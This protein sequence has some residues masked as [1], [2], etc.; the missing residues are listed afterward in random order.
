MANGLGIVYMVDRAFTTMD[1]IQAAL[2]RHPVKETPWGPI[3]PP[4][5]RPPVEAV[6]SQTVVVDLVAEFFPNAKKE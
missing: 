2:S 3:N 1:A 6:E 5:A 4:A